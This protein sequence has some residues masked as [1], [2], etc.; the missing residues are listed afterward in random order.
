LFSIIIVFSIISHF[1]SYC[2]LLVRI[3]ITA[4]TLAVTMT[5]CGNETNSSSE[6]DAISSETATSSETETESETEPETEPETESETEPEEESESETPRD[7]G[8]KPEKKHATP[9]NEELAFLDKLIQNAINAYWNNEPEEFMKYT[10]DEIYMDFVKDTSSVSSLGQDYSTHEARVESIKNLM[11]KNALSIK[12]PYNFLYY[13]FTPEFVVG[14]KD[15]GIDLLETIKTHYMTNYDT[16]YLES[17]QAFEDYNFENIVILYGTSETDDKREATRMYIIR[18][19]D[20][21]LIDTV[22]CPGL[23]DSS[24]IWG[25]FTTQEEILGGTKYK[26]GDDGHYIVD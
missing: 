12:K 18:I 22:F 7:S 11:D 21:W 9:K 14:K 19:N 25:D 20:K 6:S 4:G 26:I 1:F 13:D 23:E 8:S 10:T 24:E 3:L 2:K 15:I 17:G 16:P 5:G